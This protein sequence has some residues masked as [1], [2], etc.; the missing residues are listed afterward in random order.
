[1]DNYFDLTF[2]EQSACVF[3]LNYVKELLQKK[4]KTDG[5]NIGINIGTIAGQ[6]IHHAHIHL[7]PRY[8]G[9]VDNPIGG[10]RGVVP[11]KKDYT[12]SEK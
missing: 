4:F 6:T 7:I 10:V 3:M 11:E 2:R 8:R 9:D 12:P 5:F 1:M